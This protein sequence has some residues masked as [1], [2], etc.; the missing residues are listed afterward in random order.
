MM[1]KDQRYIRIAKACLRAIN[2]TTGG[3]QDISDE[4]QRVYDAIDEAFRQEFMTQEREMILARESLQ[5]IAG[6]D[7]DR[8]HQ[9][10]E[11]AQQALSQITYWGSSEAKH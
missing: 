5:Q 1:N 6:L 10:K 11:I 7:E 3:K 2:A 4:I 9:A 8:L